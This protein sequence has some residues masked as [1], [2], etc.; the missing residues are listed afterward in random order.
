MSK[1]GPMTAWVYSTYRDN[2]RVVT[3]LNIA[4]TI[5]YE[6]V[7]I[8]DATQE[9]ISFIYNTETKDKAEKIVSVTFTKDTNDYRLSK[10]KH[11][12]KDWF[13]VDSCLFYY[14][15]TELFLMIDSRAKNAFPTYYKSRQEGDGGDR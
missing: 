4:V 10:F 6:D 14:L 8:T 13:N 3:D 9:N 11:E 5:P 7:V 2:N 12:L 1:L 15:F